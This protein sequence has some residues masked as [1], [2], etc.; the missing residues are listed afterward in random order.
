MREVLLY[1]SFYHHGDWKK[2][3]QSIEQ[4]EPIDMDQ[5]VIYKQQLTCSYITILDKEYPDG[6]KQAFCPPYILYYIGDLNLLHHSSKVAIIGSRQHTGYG[7]KMA[8]K[9]ASEFCQHQHVVVSGADKGI[10]AIA[11]QTT[12][13]NQ[14]NTIAVV[15]NGLDCYYPKE[16]SHP[17]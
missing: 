5:L 15:G 9:L 11:H 16:N 2:I 1:F 17:T 10:D 4:K 3:Y 13:Q 8:R 12:L 7:E 6:L 14:G